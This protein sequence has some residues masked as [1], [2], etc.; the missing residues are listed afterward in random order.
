MLKAMPWMARHVGQRFIKRPLQS[1]PDARG[2]SP[3]ARNAVSGDGD[4]IM[5]EVLRA[6]GGRPGNRR[7]RG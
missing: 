5:V 6:T 3:G 7:C 4:A 1:V 2:N